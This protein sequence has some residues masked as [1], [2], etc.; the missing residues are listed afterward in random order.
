MILKNKYLLATNINLIILIFS[1]F[2]KRT[3]ITSRGKYPS[4]TLKILKKLRIDKLVLNSLHIEFIKDGSDIKNYPSLETRAREKISKKAF[5]YDSSIIKPLEK[6]LGKESAKSFFTKG[7]CYYS[8][9]GNY[10]KTYSV[11]IEHYKL[12]PKDIICLYESETSKI[13]GLKAFLNSKFLNKITTK[14]LKIKLLIGIFKMYYFRKK[15]FI[16]K[17]KFEF[18]TE[19]SNPR[20]FNGNFAEPNYLINDKNCLYYFTSRK[21]MENIDS[22]KFEKL[23]N[24]V[25]IRNKKISIETRNNFYKIILESKN[26]DIEL[27]TLLSKLFQTYSEYDFL[28]R[29]YNIDINIFLQ[30][31]NDKR[32]VRLDSAVVTSLAN[33]Y[34]AKN[35]SYQ[36]RTPYLNDYT[37][38][39]DFFNTFYSWSSFWYQNCKSTQYF[40]KIIP[41]GIDSHID[42]IEESNKIVIFTSDIAN[43]THNTKSYNI[44]II[45]I[46]KKLAKKYEEFEF[47][48]K[49]KFEEQSKKEF[50][51]IELPKNMSYAYGTY[52]LD[53][54][55]DSSFLVLAIGFTSPGFQA[56]IKGVNTIYYSELVG[57]ENKVADLEFVAYSYRDVEELFKRYLN[58]EID[59]QKYKE[60]FNHNQEKLHKE[61]ILEYLNK[62]DNN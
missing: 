53:E 11:L 60:I 61:A 5:K 21:N 34:G 4:I 40:Q 10:Y 42:K 17:E 62:E 44:N 46:A 48:I 20:F 16:K 43:E 13:I 57:I 19:V 50:K 29:V 32:Y 18:S 22:N 28:F 52:N 3:Y 41:T 45:E 30:F 23:N 51:N 24:F 58:N 49:T 8:G 6:L 54:L 37:F 55:I 56:L 9:V 33:K 36:T 25:D 14:Y 47:V 15:N 38:Y 39:Y 2:M 12:N 27:Y 7:I 1:F 35:I 59:I 31:T 26:I